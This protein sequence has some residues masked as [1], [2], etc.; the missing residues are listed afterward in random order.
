LRWLAASRAGDERLWLLSAAVGIWALTRVMFVVVSYIALLWADHSHA[1]GHGIVGQWVEW[2]ATWYLAMAGDVRHV[3]TVS[4]FPLYPLVVAAVTAVIGPNHRPLAGVLVANIAMLIGAVCM[5]LLGFAES[6][7]V[8]SALGAVRAAL[9]YPLAFTTFAPMSEGLFF[10]LI[11]AALLASRLRM[12][13]LAALSGLLAA[14]TRPTGVI[15]APV[16]LVEYGV[17]SGWLGRHRSLR[18]LARQLAGGAALFAAPLAGLAVVMFG[19]W[20]STGDPL[21]F[22]H[23]QQ[24]FWHHQLLPPWESVRL[25]IEHWYAPTA[26]YDLMVID[27]VAILGFGAVT[28]ASI[29]VLP[30]S[31]TAFML[32]LLATTVA[33]PIPNYP[34]V[35]ASAAR[36]LIVGIPVFLVIGRYTARHPA[37]DFFVV[38]AG[39]L[40]QGLF[41]LH[42]ISGLWVS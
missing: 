23:I 35:Y 36:Y 22:G 29:K 19:E 39:F 9:A 18:G 41:A 7:R 33:A 28:L 8:N 30:M 1:S 37:L 27:G 34:D 15:L 10:A 38:G 3:F 20:L 31:F 32:L 6:K 4:F 16:L 12:W 26:Q 2:D 5:A 21:L 11:A 25:F 42:F 13:W 24:S 14:M 40:L 17:Q